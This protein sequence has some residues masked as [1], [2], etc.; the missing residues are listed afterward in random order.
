M[1]KKGLL[2]LNFNDNDISKYSIMNNE[3]NY[4][5]VLNCQLKDNEKYNVIMGNAFTII[6]DLKKQYENNNC[7]FKIREIIKW[8]YDHSDKLINFINI[9][10]DADD[11]TKI[12]A[13]LKNN[14]DVLINKNILLNLDLDITDDYLEKLKLLYKLHYNISVSIDNGLNIYNMPFNEYLNVLI[15]CKKIFNNSFNLASN[16][17]KI[18]YIYDELR[19]INSIINKNELWNMILEMLYIPNTN[20][21]V[22]GD[23]EYIRSLVYIDDHRY[24]ISG[25]YSFDNTL[26]THNDFKYFAKSCKEI[27]AFNKQDNINN[28]SLLINDEAVANYFSSQTSNVQILLYLRKYLNLIPGNM[29]KIVIDDNIDYRLIIKEYA[30]LFDHPILANQFLGALYNVKKFKYEQ[31]NLNN[32]F[33]LDLLLGIVIDSKFKIDSTEIETIKQVLNPD[34]KGDDLN[35]Y[36]KWFIDYVK[37]NGLNKDYQNI[38]LNHKR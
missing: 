10:I 12:Y 14:K 19:K 15:R 37:Y 25:F 20:F 36:I 4:D 38:K 6:K 11:V 17:E 2:V 34:F 35:S 9:K 33:D 26:E 27:E 3:Y 16:F 29:E 21:I 8:A 5:Y 28:V 18:L 23:H 13:F 7:D 24:N 31:D 32:Y 1:N 30:K 22:K